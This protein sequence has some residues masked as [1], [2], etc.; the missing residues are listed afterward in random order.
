MNRATFVMVLMLCVTACTRNIRPQHTFER[1]ELVIVSERIGEAIDVQERAEF[2]LFSYVDDFE[3]AR[4]Y[5]VE[6]HGYE[7][8]IFAGNQEFIACNRDPDALL[9]MRDYIDRR[10]V[11]MDSMPAFEGKW[12]IVDYD[13]LGQAI[14]KRE[15]EM[16]M[17]I[18][19]SWRGMLMLAGGTAGC[20]GSCLIVG[21]PSLAIDVP[22]DYDN[23]E[24]RKKWLIIGGA[25]AL[26]GVSGWFI[27]K[28]FERRKALEKIKEA[29]KPR[30]VQ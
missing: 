30:L 12:S 21:A 1:K 10:E 29:R 22:T 19:G 5:A 13:T 3:S 28:E 17:P 4:F 8:E 6:G 25:T 26:G 7:V 15:I 24:N 9:I 20:I 18:K 23:S 11:I 14:T 16:N 27:G 2:G